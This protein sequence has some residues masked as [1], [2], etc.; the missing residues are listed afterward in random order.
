MIIQCINT[1]QRCPMASNCY[2]SIRSLDV[3]GRQDLN[4][5]YH[6]QQLCNEADVSTGRHSCVIAV[7][8][9]IRS[10]ASA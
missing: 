10:Q 2:H 1:V 7:Y 9:S 5:R 6:Q 4:W 3:E 8:G